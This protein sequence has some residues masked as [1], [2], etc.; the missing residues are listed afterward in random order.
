MPPQIQ[1]RESKIQIAAFVSTLFHP[2]L[3]IPVTVLVLT[4]D[5]RVSAI[6][7]AATVLPLLALT[8]RNVRRG[9]W[10]N[11]D[12]SNRSQRSGLYFAA[13][14]LT[15]LAAGVLAVTGAPMPL[16]RGTAM[17]GGLLLAAALLS[18]FLKTSLHLLF[19]AWCGVLIFRAFPETVW[20]IPFVIATLA[21]SRLYLKRHTI[22][23]VAVG[24]AIGALG[25]L[26][27]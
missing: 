18:P 24:F 12:V 6:I 8:L 2:L 3:V 26:L 10:S 14:P 23:E 9:T 15:F 7:A 11:F 22:A 13:V 1:H 5:L 19:A 20:F 21:W 17:V 16:V 27:V 25:A 4:R